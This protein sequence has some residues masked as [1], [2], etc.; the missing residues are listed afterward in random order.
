ME[1]M[2]GRPKPTILK[3]DDYESHKEQD[4]VQ[5]CEEQHIL[6]SPTKG[7]LTPKEQVLDQA[8]NGLVPAYHKRKY[9]VH[10]CTRCPN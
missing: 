2:P 5:F 3:L 7:G 10:A 8:A 6:I 9:N 4:F 1:G